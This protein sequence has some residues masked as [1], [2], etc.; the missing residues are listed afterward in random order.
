MK[1]PST[2]QTVVYRD[3]LVIDLTTT[4]GVDK[5]LN[6]LNRRHRET[7][8]ALRA[9]ELVSVGKQLSAGLLT[10]DEAVGA[11]ARIG[12]FSLPFQAGDLDYITGL[13][14]IEKPANSTDA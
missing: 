9:V 4:A 2:K 12:Q 8:M 11:A 7:V 13:R 10:S 3:P 6:E 5:A 14:Y 1:Q